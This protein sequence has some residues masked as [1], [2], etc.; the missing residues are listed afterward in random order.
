MNTTLST[1]TNT[2]Y[3]TVDMTRVDKA[4]KDK[5]NASTIRQDIEK[6]VRASGDAASWRCIAVT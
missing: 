4:E 2:L 6:E 1:I 5:A 3:Y